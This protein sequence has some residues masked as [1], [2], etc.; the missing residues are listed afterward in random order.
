M[1]GARA[2]SGDILAT[3]EVFRRTAAGTPFRTAYRAVA[4]ELKKGAKLPA[5]TPTEELLAG[6]WAEVAT[7]WLIVDFLR[8]Q[9][10]R[11]QVAFALTHEVLAH[12]VEDIAG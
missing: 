2:L 11:E 9:P 6:I 3:D 7:G 5:L 8:D 1:R 12:L 4:A 10:S